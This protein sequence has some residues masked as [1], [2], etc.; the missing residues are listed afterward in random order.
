MN[1]LE[2]KFDLKKLQKQDNIVDLYDEDDSDLVTIGQQ[3]IKGYK[4]DEASREDWRTELEES[5][6]MDKQL[7][8]KKFF[9]WPGAANIQFPLITETAIDF[10][11]NTTPSIIRNNQAIKC[12]IR[13]QDK[14]GIKYQKAQWASD[15]MSYQLLQYDKDWK[16]NTAKLI[17]MLGVMGTV[18]RKVYYDHIKYKTCFEVV[19]PLRVVVNY[20][21]RNLMD[22]PRITHV[23]D[24]YAND[25][26]EQ[27]RKGYYSKN[28]DVEELL[29]KKINPNNGSIEATSGDPNPKFIILEQHCWLDLDG[30]G[31]KE[32]Y[33]VTVEAESGKVFRIYNRFDEIIK[34][35]DK[36]ICIYPKQYWVDYHCIYSSDGGFYSRGFG[37]ILLPINKA[38]NS[39][40][41][42]LI[43]S[44][45]LATVQ[46]GFIGKGLRLKNGTIEFEMG[47]WKVLDTASGADIK[48]NIFPLPT[49]EPSQTLFNL[50][51]L[52][53]QTGKDLA[54]NTA[55]QQ[56]QQPAQNVAANTVNTLLEQSTSVPNH[57]RE[58]IWESLSKEF[59]MLF[60]NNCNYPNPELFQKVLDEENAVYDEVFELDSLD[61]YPIGDPQL[62]SMSQRL[63]KA[64][65]LQT[66]PTADRREVD[67]YIAQT[68]QLD[69]EQLKKLFPPP[70][71]NQPPSP[72]AQKSLSQAHLFDTQ[73]RQIELQTTIAMQ[74]AELTPQ[75]IMMELK[76][77]ESRVMESQA[78]AAKMGKDAAHNDGKLMI[79]A[80]KMQQEQNRKEQDAIHKQQMDYGNMQLSAA[81]AANKANKVD[82]DLRAKVMDNA[83]KVKVAEISAEAKKDSGGSKSEGKKYSEEDIAHTARLK[84]MSVNMVKSLLGV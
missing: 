44:G 74:E 72:D 26:I 36:V 4:L 51:Q 73:A 32:P 23:H 76:E 18:F 19:S 79:Q 22:A 34:E 41:N 46:G 66:M 28:I 39:T 68:L 10:A 42:Q 61:V 43:D 64:Q 27:Q 15:Y 69:P 70:D 24:R 12:G 55:V 67:L 77:A 5:L 49:K 81:S 65:M 17:Q 29:P 56:G 58:H 14:N 52:L 3:V 59:T 57:I 84:G 37:A 75:K 13:G 9:P 30:D 16:S 50:L 83:T 35:K 71:P 48:A 63:V 11:A 7:R 47:K 60:E 33:I 2:N 8:K 1:E 40:M 80:Q 25:I 82:V 31:L 38:I 20:S 21:T 54:Q 45:T 53:I 62:S 6:K 78:R